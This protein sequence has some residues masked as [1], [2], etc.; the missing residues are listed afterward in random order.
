M[1]AR[2]LSALAIPALLAAC[3]SAQQGTPPPP[4]PAALAEISAA[5]F[6]LAP[7][8]RIEVIVRTAPELSR[9]L[10][11]AP[12][13][14]IRLPYTG[15][16]TATGLSSAELSRALS[17]ELA[18]EL[19]DPGVDII[20]LE[21]A[22]HGVFVTGEV[23]TPS[24]VDLPAPIGLHQAIERAGGRTRLAA[25]QAALLIR[26]LPG[27]EIRTLP[28]DLAPAQGAALDL[29]LRRFDIV[30]IPPAKPGSPDLA[31]WEA[32]IPSLPPS[33]RQYFEAPTPRD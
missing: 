14:R 24:L 12:D 22:P 18:S 16:I 17:A 19:I 21:L 31:A 4:D 15:E 10:V 30:L 2:L 8:D 13:G 3:A 29:P 9:Q 28:L 7:G 6:L 27:G 1:R 32:L 26:R 20:A 11:I 25:P 33:F 23:R 5:P